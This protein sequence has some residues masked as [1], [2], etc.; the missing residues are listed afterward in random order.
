[1]RLVSTV[2]ALLL[3]CGSAAAAGPQTLQGRR[4]DD[5]LR[6]LQREGL[7][8]VFSSEIVTPRMRVTAEPRATNPRQQL[9]E[10]LAPNGLS[11]ESGPGGVILIVRAHTAAPTQTATDTVAR[12][13]PHG[14]AASATVAAPPPSYSDHVTVS[15]TIDTAAATGASEATLDRS[16]LQESGGPVDA[17]GLAA[18]HVMPR[19]SAVDDFRSDFSVRGSPYRQIGIVVDGVATPW[20]QHTVYGR[21]D[22]GSVSMFGSDNL[23]RATLQAGA[24]PRVY[25]DTLGAQLE[26]NLREG[27]RTS[28]RIT[29][30][31]GGMITAVVGE[32]P[33]GADDRGSWIAGLR[34]SYHS[35]PPGAHSSD[36][37]GFGFADLNAKLVYDVSPGQQIS[38]TA[39]GGQSTL[40]TID[41]LP[42]APRAMGIDGAALLNVGWRS[43]FASHTVVR[44]RLFGV[45]QDL[46]AN[47]SNGQVVGVSN[48]RALGYRGEVQHEVLGGV[49]EAGGEVSR[50]S[51]SRAVGASGS[52]TVPYSLRSAWMTHAA[53]VDF[54]RASASGVSFEAGVRASDST[55][56]QQHALVPWI[57]G[58]WHLAPDWTINASAGASRQFAD[59]DAMMGSAGS[60]TLRPER[61]THFDVGIE[62][63]LSTRIRWQATLFDRLEQDVLRGPGSVLPRQTPSIEPVVPGSYRN[64]LSGVAR[65][66]EFVV[67]PEQKGRLSG[68]LSYA[69]AVMRQHDVNTQETFWSDFDRRHTFNAAGMFRIGPQ[70][71]AGLVVRAASGVPIPGYFDL[72]NGTLMS[73]DQLNTVRLPP[74]MR[75][76]GQLQRRVFSSRHQATLFA[77]IVNALNRGNEGLATGVVEPTTGVATGFSRPLVPRKVSVGITIA[78]SR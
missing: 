66:L 50:L 71:S 76:D 38:V 28:T 12:R 1:M 78:L 3:F 57:L 65:G 11:A 10:I 23:E 62:Q 59:L 73:G 27:S 52:A 56:M 41:E 70:A 61:A 21:S 75:L 36:N 31:A 40:D 74:Y 72:R 34:N 44:Q 16:A 63:R 20:L 17:D 33:I 46:S 48:N 13:H 5:A 30:T 19:V 55:L 22:L 29:G 4:L 51:E 69:Y 14:A 25:D 45:G 53:Y 68:W 54:A 64:A 26:L 35:W 67:T 9:D 7:P 49:L 37:P 6:L 2:V 58:A 39:L 18:V 15:S 43:V 24:Y 60:L 47:L 77:E 42:V 8:I 32:G